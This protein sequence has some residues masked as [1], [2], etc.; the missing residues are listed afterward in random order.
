MRIQTA[1]WPDN[2]GECQ[3]WVPGDEHLKR[4]HPLYTG[5]RRFR[6]AFTRADENR[7]RS[8]PLGKARFCRSKRRVSMNDF[9][10]H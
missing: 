8:Y 2:N 7:K 3:L 6:I 5:F 10:L 4:Q 1:I 9:R